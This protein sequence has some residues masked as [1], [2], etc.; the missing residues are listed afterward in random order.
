MACMLLGSDGFENFLPKYRIDTSQPFKL[1]DNDKSQGILI[2]NGSLDWC[3]VHLYGNHNR[4]G[5]QNK[6]NQCIKYRM[7][8]LK[9]K[10][11]NKNDRLF[12][13]INRARFEALPF[14]IILG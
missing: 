9:R 10:M 1:Q 4:T 7:T 12:Q 11:L 14:H 2:E 13:G 8:I 5:N 3:P 6:R